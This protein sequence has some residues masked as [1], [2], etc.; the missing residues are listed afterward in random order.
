MTIDV[1]HTTDSYEVYW[2]HEDDNT[3]FIDPDELFYYDHNCLDYIRDLIMDGT[4]TRDNI[5][6]YVGEFE[7]Y[8]E[9]YFDEKEMEDD[10]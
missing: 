6:N 5:T 9:E 2:I 10:E 8:I 7:D 4:L 1:I 3:S